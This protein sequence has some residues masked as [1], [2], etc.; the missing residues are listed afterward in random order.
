MLVDEI[1]IKDFSWTPIF[2]GKHLF[3]HPSEQG[4]VSIDANR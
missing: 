1:P 3:H 2:L 4:D